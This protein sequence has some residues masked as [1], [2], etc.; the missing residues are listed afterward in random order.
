MKREV[1]ETYSQFDGNL[2]I[3]FSWEASD[4]LGKEYWLL[5]KSFTYYVG[6]IGSDMWV[7][8]PAGFL[9]DGASV[10]GLVRGL[11][12][13]MGRLS[14]PAFLH[15]YLCETYE[16]STENGTEI[17]QIPINRKL[18]DRIF[19]EALLVSKVPAW[20]IFV[21]KLVLN[22]H[23]LI[24]RPTKPKVSDRKKKME[25]ILRDQEL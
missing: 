11:V 20:R 7:T 22:L 9:S 1:S 12:P 25:Q 4:Y 10:P 23:R 3:T 17:K 19:F 8:V 6:K 2:Y 15:D 24:R 14:Q 21:I 16:V 5:R 13:R 18:V